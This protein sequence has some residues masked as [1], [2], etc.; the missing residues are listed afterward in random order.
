MNNKY[1]EIYSKRINRFNIIISAFSLLILSFFFIIQILPNKELEDAL[2]KAGF[3]EKIII[4]ARGNITDRNNIELA[5]TINKYDFWVNTKKNNE[6]I[7]QIVSLFSNTFNKPEKYY[8]DLLNQK[9]SHKIIEKNII[10]EKAFTIINQ[11]KDFNGLRYTKKT[12]RFYQY[13]EFASHTIGYMNDNGTGIIGIEKKLN[14]LLSGDTIITNLQKGA[15]GKFFNQEIIN[16]NDIKG[17]NVQLTIDIEF[18]KILQEELHKAVINTNAKGANGIIVDPHNGE[19]LAMASM[20]DFNPNSYNEYPQENFNNSVISDTYEPG[21]TFKIL[22]IA[23][24]LNDTKYSISDS[25]D[26]E[27]GEYKLSNNKLMHDHEENSFLTIKDILV[28][29]SNIGIVKLSESYD[30]K[31]LYKLIKKFGFGSS[32]KIP[33]NNEA[34]GKIRSISNWSKT[35]K[36]YI[37]IGQELSITNLQLAM[38]YSVI[39]N[40]GNLVK[41]SIIK[42]I[43]KNNETT[44]TNKI[45]TIRHNVLDKE[46]A[47]S[48]LG[49]LREVVENGTAQ[50]INL[51]NYDIAGK[52]GTAQKFKDGHLNNYIATFASIFPAGN[53]VEPK[54]VMIVT[55]DEPEYGKH[56]A[57][58]SAVPSS[59]EIIKRMLIKDF[60]FQNQLAINNIEINDKEDILL[61]KEYIIDKNRFPDLTGKTLKEALK[62]TNK[63]NVKIRPDGISGLIINQSIKPGSK[64][65]KTE[66]T[67]CEVKIKI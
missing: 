31:A 8:I 28:H 61:N 43:D 52:T 5:T 34:K 32:T 57:N 66:E 36:N 55:I 60:D 33:L 45:N 20:P 58:L 51:K 59:R 44:Y 2:K 15:K 64:I 38:A 19:I 48:I 1:F 46:I 7:N 17:A 16:T 47:D 37:S 3:R 12:S 6:N 24:I 41:P 4:G 18:Q 23:I 35:S 22:P 39:A 42:K 40:G 53:E 9:S 13:N 67:I 62:I 14:H 63:I 50:S 11:I 49:M 29:S 27:N 26:C 21:S 25:I 54:Y 10:D 56:W 30:N 65:N